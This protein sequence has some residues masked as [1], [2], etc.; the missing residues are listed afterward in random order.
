MRLRKWEEVRARVQLECEDMV[1]L[2]RTSQAGG[3]KE[4][5]PSCPSSTLDK[6]EGGS[7]AAGV[8][9]GDI[10]RND[11]G[12]VLYMRKPETMHLRQWGY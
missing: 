10:Y 5:E 11:R 2:V 4:V 1:P 6:Y 7:R 8:G 3:G 12:T 9:L